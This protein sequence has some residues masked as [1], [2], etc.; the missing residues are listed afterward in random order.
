MS[1][2]KNPFRINVGFLINQP[3]GTSRTFTF[4]AERFPLEPEVTLTDFRGTAEINRVVQGI[5]V[6]G[7]FWTNMEVECVR[8]LE[9]FLQPLHAE[10]DELYAFKEEDA[11]ESGQLLSETAFIDLA[12]VVREYLLLELP[13]SPQCSADC[14]GLCEMCGVNLN[15]SACEHHP[16]RKTE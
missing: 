14:Q 2:A 13:I 6:E 3:V 4:E 15:V 10:F 9:P 5:L 8:C 12:P 16:E 1:N 7:D 11:D